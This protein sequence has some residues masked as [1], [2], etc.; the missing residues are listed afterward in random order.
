MKEKEGKR[1]REREIKRMGNRERQIEG[2]GGGV[3]KHVGIIGD[4]IPTNR[5]NRNR[6]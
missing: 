1:E 3:A 5:Y 4:T 2:G 6:L